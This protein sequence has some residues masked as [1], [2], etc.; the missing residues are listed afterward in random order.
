VRPGDRLPLGEASVDLIVSDFTFEHVSDPSWVA[1]ELDRVLVP[2]GWI[3]ARTPNRRGYIG[4]G[5]RLVPNRLHVRFLRTL[6]PTK[7]AEDTF[8]T[9]Y[10]LNTPADLRHWFPPPAWEH[11]VWA[12]DSEPVYV[13]QSLAA[14][15]LNRA[16]FA[17][18]PPGLRSML[19]VFLHKAPGDGPAR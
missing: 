16:V 3:C 5:A 8:P 15:R 14:G 6:Q 2:G 11:S 13:G 9:A 7:K 19:N 4:L 12:T 17:L 1:A 18:T 10:R